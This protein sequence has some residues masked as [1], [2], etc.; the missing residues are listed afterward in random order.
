MEQQWNRSGFPG[1]SC[2]KCRAAL[3]NTPSSGIVR[4][5][6]EMKTPAK[7]VRRRSVPFRRDVHIKTPALCLEHLC[8]ISDIVAFLNFNP[9]IL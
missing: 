2:T 8:L 6:D 9:V 5:Q 1:K 7:D 3:I 4:S